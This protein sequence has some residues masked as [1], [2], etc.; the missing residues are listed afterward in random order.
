MKRKFIFLLTIITL[1][2]FSLSLANAQT[3]PPEQKQEFYKASVTA[4]LSEEQKTIGGQRNLMQRLQVRL[5]DGPDKGKALTIENG[6]VFTLT[7]AQKAKAGE[8]V[9]LRRMTANGKTS[10]VVVDKYRLPQ[11][12]WI[13]AGF[14]LVVSLIAGRKGV[15]AIIGMLISLTVIMWF[16]VPQILAGSDPIMISIMGSV[17]IL[18]VTMYL[19]HGFSKQTT[20]ALG[21]TAISLFLTGVFAVLFVWFARLSGMGSEDAYSLQ[22]GFGQTINF[23]GLLLGAII[24][25]TLGVL[26]DVTTTQAATI[27][28]LAEANPKST[29]E[30]L[31]RK[32]M[33]V[34]REH[35]ASVVNT[36]VL[37]YA[38]ASIG[39]FIFLHLGIQ[40]NT[41]PLW[42]MLN[43]E[44]IIEEVI[45]T[46]AGSL[47][48]ILAVPITTIL[49]AFFA[50]NEIKIS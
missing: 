2:F 26:D 43:S 40:H 28:E 31:V 47:G 15:G 19:A 39:I 44:V 22:Q 48:L 23:Q 20:L 12:G 42:V 35:I 29:F 50:K 14:F 17:V 1:N 10:Y 41:Q 33:R 13:L 34:G 49:A 45:R 32:G 37:A 11:V 38:G 27:N 9:I 5:L 36:L 8:T 6:G 25:G 16:I 21:A 30:D 3:A 18:L 46:I 7:S 24:I 4:V